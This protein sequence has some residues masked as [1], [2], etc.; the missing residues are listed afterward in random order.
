MKLFFV[1]VEKNRIELKK[2]VMGKTISS[3]EI[4]LIFFTPKLVWY[5]LKYNSYKFFSWTVKMFVFRLWNF[6]HSENSFIKLIR[7][8]GDRS[9]HLFKYITII[10]NSEHSNDKPFWNRFKRV[11]LA[12]Y[13]LLHDSICSKQFFVDAKY[14]WRPIPFIYS[15][16]S[17]RNAITM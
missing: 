8:S 3:D 17:I 2:R 1:V 5:F 4:Y 9:N 14:V 16:Y 7:K 15:H 10:T 12:T 13:Q 6:V 11:A